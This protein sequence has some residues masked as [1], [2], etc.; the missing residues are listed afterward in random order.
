MHHL[1]S[2]VADEPARAWFDQALRVQPRSFFTEV[3]G[4]QVHYLA[5]N[6]EERHKPTLLLIHGY[7]AHARWWSFIAP[8]FTDS[9]RVVALDLSGMGDSGRREQYDSQAFVDDILGVVDAAELAPVTL[10]GHS[11]GG[12]RALQACAQ[13]PERIHRA[14]VVDTYVFMSDE[15]RPNVPLPRTVAQPY[16]SMEQ[17]LKRF[18][19]TPEQPPGPTW[20]AD[21][22]AWHSLRRVNGGWDWKF[23]RNLPRLVSV[24]NGLLELA[25]VQVPVDFVVGEGSAVVSPEHAARM[26]AVLPK[27]RGPVVVPQGFHHIMMSQPLALVATLR[28]LLA[29]EQTLHENN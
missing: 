4:C 8:F 16:A 12:G 29:V 22:V 20:L 25:K 3:Q 7:R 15:P 5:W 24:P 6:P 21:Y 10:I 11:F 2:S 18:R 14:I 17:A 9:Y 23:D 26:V 19:L 13:A 1:Q 28:A 27:A